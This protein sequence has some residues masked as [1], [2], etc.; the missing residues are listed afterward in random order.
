[1]IHVNE[2]LCIGCNACI[3]A[4]PVP[5]ANRYD[6]NVVR[7]NPDQCIK[8]GECIKGC[9]HGARY[10]DDDLENMLGSLKHEKISLI[11]APAIKTALD[12]KWRHVLKWLKD[13]GVN[14]IYDA[15]FGA[16]ICTY[17]HVQ[18]MNKN[19]T[20][21][22][23]SQPCAAIINYAEKHKP[24]LLPSMSP[25]HSPLMCTAIYVRKYLN[26]TDKIFALTP[27]IA[28]EDEFK[29]TGVVSGNV[30]FRRL[31]DYIKEHKINLPSGHSDFEFSAT[32]GFDGGFYPIPGGLKECLKVLA[33]DLSVSTS[34]G[35]H[36]VYADFDE[37]LAADKSS[38]PSVYDVLSCEFGCNSGA[39]ASEKFNMFNSYN[40]MTNVKGWS[41]TRSSSQRFHKRIFRSLRLE[42]FIRKYTNRYVGIVPSA[43]ELDEIFKSMGKYTDADKHVD[44]HACGLK[45]CRDMAITIYAGNNNPSNCVMHEKRRISLIT[46]EIEQNHSELQSAVARINDSLA[47]LSNKIQPIA[48]HTTENATK[49]ASIKSDMNRINTDIGDISTG[50]EN[51]AEYVSVI[52]TSVE[53][54]NRILN[55]IAGISEQ[56]NILAINASIEASRAG[57][58]GKGFAVVA[59]E[60]RTLSIKSADTL[61]EARYHTNEMLSKIVDIK[62]AS[63]KIENQVDA[64]KI[65]VTNTDKAIEDLNSSSTLINE[66]IEEVKTII[67]NLNRLASQLS[68][69]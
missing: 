49:N 52:G 56:T 54:Y 42:D 12:G 8:C 57:E 45:S 22:I 46:D 55:K 59:D 31:A 18:Y 1:M 29:N 2:N 11:V 65:S 33:P 43:R 38:L 21:K 67:D 20:A 69:N 35:V 14:E 66:S 7:T 26:S 48:Q 17:L 6:G 23:I 41:K 37:Y 30:T 47:A 10:Y 27:C 4:C 28:K 63:S 61:K 62:S 13:Q 51:I 53:E 60:V 64:T 58:A 39:G 32:R 34:E 50:V 44:C 36:K 3:R 24:E 19:P 16:D 9:S 68:R 25:I 15:S 40:I 5:N